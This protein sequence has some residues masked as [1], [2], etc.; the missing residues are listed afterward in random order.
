VTVSAPCPPL[1]PLSYYEGYPPLEDL[2]LIGDGVT[3]ALVGRDGA[4]VWLCLPCFDS[5]PFFCSLLDAE[6]GGSFRTAPEGLDGARQRY[7]PD[8]GVLVTEL[9]C[10]TF[11]LADAQR[12]ATTWCSTTAGLR[13]HGTTQCRPA[14]VFRVEEAPLLLPAPTEAYD[15][16]L[17]AKPQG[18]PRPP[19]RGGQGAV[20][21][22]RQPHRLSGQRPGRRPP[23]RASL[24]GPSSSSPAGSSFNIPSRR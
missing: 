24:P 6:R 13:T 17:Y 10:T 9:R 2:G 12:R 11:D 5:E 19:H 8:S 22:P 18:P 16:P 21:H 4:V 7:E 23:G 3:A 14:E 20:L 15:L 1:S